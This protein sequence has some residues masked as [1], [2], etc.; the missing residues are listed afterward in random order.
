MGKD[1]NGRYAI[2]EISVYDGFVVIEGG[3]IDWRIDIAEWDYS[4]IWGRASILSIRLIFCS[5]NRRASSIRQALSTTLQTRSES[6]E[7]PRGIRRCRKPGKRM[8]K[9]TAKNRVHSLQPE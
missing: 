5:S 3:L 6:W 8:G 4:V 9:K 2:G 1:D 7:T